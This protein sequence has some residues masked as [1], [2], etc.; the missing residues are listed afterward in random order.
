MPL[1]YSM[2]RKNP[3]S[4]RELAVC[5]RVK[6]FRTKM[7]YSR[8]AFARKLNID[9]SMLSSIE[10]G[11]ARLKFFLAKRLGETFA[12]SFRWLAEGAGDMQPYDPAGHSSFASIPQYATFTEVYDRHL[13]NVLKERAKVAD[14]FRSKGIY[15]FNATAPARV[16]LPGAGIIQSVA[17]EIRTGLDHLPEGVWPAFEAALIDAAS[18][19]LR[20]YDAGQRKQLTEPSSPVSN[21]PVKAQWL[22]LKK[23]LQKETASPGAK[24]SLAKFIG[25]SADLTRISQWLSDSKSAREP[26]AEYALR[27]QYWLEHPEARS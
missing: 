2:P 23:K 7:D 8:V 1:S 27:M 25:V 22:H 10:H 3:L 6:L 21:E 18:E 16:P 14:S 20:D 12:V 24:T 17:T 15:V 9:S 13:K 26:G 4:E 11:R 5:S 19:F